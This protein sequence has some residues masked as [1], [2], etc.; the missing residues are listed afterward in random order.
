MNPYFKVRKFLGP[1]KAEDFLKVWTPFSC[2]GKF[3]KLKSWLKSQS[4]LSEDQKKEFSQKKDKI[5]VESPQASTSKNLPQQV[6]KNGKQK[7]KGK[8]KP[9]GNRTYQQNY[10]NPKKEKISL[11]NVFNISTTLMEIK[12]KEE[13]RMRSPFQ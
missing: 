8:G 10:K 9:K 5:P 3:K 6:P 11:D 13:E 4:I 7:G 1:K 2:K 12:N